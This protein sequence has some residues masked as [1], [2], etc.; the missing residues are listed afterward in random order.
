M[1]RKT[2]LVISVVLLVGTVVL[3]VRSYAVNVNAVWT[4]EREQ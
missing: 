1:I 4:S 3:W 2:L